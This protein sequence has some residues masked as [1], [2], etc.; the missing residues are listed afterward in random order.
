MTNDELGTRLDRIDTLI[1]TLPESERGRIRALVIETRE[2]H[3]RIA[4]SSRQ[5]IEA[6][7]DWRVRLKYIIFDIEATQREADARRGSG[8]EPGQF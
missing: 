3:A 6:I 2:R 8:G 7:D 1:E 5:A 4:E